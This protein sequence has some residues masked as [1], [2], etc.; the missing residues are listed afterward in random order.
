MVRDT[1]TGAPLAAGWRLKLGGALFAL[2]IVGPFLFLPLMTAMGLSNAMM[3]TVS[4]VILAGAEV[5]GIAAVAV[6][7][8]SGYAYIKGRIFGFLRQYGPPRDVGRT[9]Y[10]VGLV[11]FAVPVL[12]GWQAPYAEGLIPG[13]R[14][15]VI[16][17]AV[18]GDLLLL[19]SL[20]VLGGDFWEKVRALFI[21]EIKA[22]S[23]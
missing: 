10:N 5:L 1:D 23:R 8:K 13:Y 15:N 18:A 7:G 12:F 20:F 2:S 14:E 11:M 9:R 19:A 22:V 3:A 21:H 4:G 6:L 16:A 17:F